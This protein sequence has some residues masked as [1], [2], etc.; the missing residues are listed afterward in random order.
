MEAVRVQVSRVRGRLDRNSQTHSCSS[1]GFLGNHTQH[2][3]H[4][5]AGNPTDL[6]ARSVPEIGGPAL[7]TGGKGLS[8]LGDGLNGGEI[9]GIVI[10]VLLLI[11]AFWIG[12]RNCNKRAKAKAEAE[13][14]AGAD[15]GTSQYHPGPVGQQTKRRH[16]IPAI[17]THLLQC[18]TDLYRNVTGIEELGDELRLSPMRL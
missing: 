16:G 13:G 18:S 5:I 11:L 2:L 14:A 12:V 10:G 8:T 9:A 15:T 6:V 3:P 17:V 1:E 7:E 4:T